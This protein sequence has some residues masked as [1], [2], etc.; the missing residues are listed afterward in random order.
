MA[1]DHV[2]ERDPDAQLRQARR[3]RTPRSSSSASAHATPGAL[4]T[5]ITASPMRLTTFAPAAA[6][7]VAGRRLEAGEHRRRAARDRAWRRGPCS[8]EVGEPHRELRRRSRS[9]SAASLAVAPADRLEVVAV[10]RVDRVDDAREQLRRR[11]SRSVR[12]TSTNC[13]SPRSGASMFERSSAISAS[14]ICADRLA[15]RAHELQDRARRPTNSRRDR[16]T[17]RTT[18]RRPS[19]KR[20]RTAADRRTPRARHTREREHRRRS[21][22][23]PRPRASVNRSPSGRS[24]AERGRS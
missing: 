17:G 6:I 10:Q 8:R 11:L 21:P 1:H 20:A 18:R 5:N 14:A 23:R 16:A 19:P 24:V 22:A 12:A 7:D 13:W 15:E 3:P 4:V 2:A 9:T